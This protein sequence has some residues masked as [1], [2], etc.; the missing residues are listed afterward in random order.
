MEAQDAPLAG[1]GRGPARRHTPDGKKG[2]R[3]R[4]SEQTR[5]PYHA[6]PAFKVTTLIDNLHAPWSLAFLPAEKSS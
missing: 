4:F 2:Q 6:T 3:S 1:H 5:A